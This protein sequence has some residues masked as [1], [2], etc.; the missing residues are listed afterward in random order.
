VFPVSYFFSTFKQ[1]SA[2]LDLGNSYSLFFLVVVV[3]VVAAA[4]FYFLVSGS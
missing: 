1:I 2:K 4:N 3:V